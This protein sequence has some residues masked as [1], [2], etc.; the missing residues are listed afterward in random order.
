MPNTQIKHKTHKEARKSNTL[1]KDKASN[2]TR[3]KYNLDLQVS[4]NLKYDVL[5]A[6]V[7]KNGQYA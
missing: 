5:K 7:G 2:R 1:P 3:L 4:K 6:L